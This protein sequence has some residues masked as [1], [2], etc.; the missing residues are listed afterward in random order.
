MWGYALGKARFLPASRRSAVIFSGLFLAMAAHTLFNLL[1]YTAIGFALL[2][3][4]VVPVLWLIVQRK[5]NES[6]NNSMYRPK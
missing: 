2:I 4:V 1:L 6:L 5:I 3:L